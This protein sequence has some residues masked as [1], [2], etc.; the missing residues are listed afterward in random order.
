MGSGAFG[1][2]SSAM[3]CAASA[4]SMTITGVEDFLK[5]I[6]VE[7][8]RHFKG[9]KE[10]QTLQQV[11][12]VEPKP[13]EDGGNE[14][15]QLETI[16]SNTE[17]PA[18]QSTIESKIAVLGDFIDTDAL[19]PGHTLTTCKT[20][21][22]FGRYVL[23]FTHPDFRSKAAGGQ[24]VVVAGEAFGVGSSRESAVL[25]LKGVGVK[26]VIARSFAFIYSRNQPSL[27]LLGIV[28]KDDEFYALAMEG[29]EIEI[30]IEQRRIEIG[31]RKFS[32]DLSTMEYKL[33]VNQGIA[34]TYGRF[35]KSI[36]ERLMQEE[37]EKPATKA[38]VATVDSRLNW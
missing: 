34:K 3:V 29:E 28:M 7:F 31:G 37:P 35:G 24:Q 26:A 9:D 14:T 11:Q 1:H 17:S 30:D 12:Y 25:A 38:E 19:S 27:G 4:F 16:V 33:T 15:A 8:F 18:V 10:G 5:E 32:F 21:E 36:W 13:H 6:D 2:L 20:E 23:E 22:E